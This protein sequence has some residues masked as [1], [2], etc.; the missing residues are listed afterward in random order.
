MLPLLM[1][2]HL[3]TPDSVCADLGAGNGLQ[4]LLLQ[5]LCPHRQTIQVELSGKMI[6]VGKLYQQALGLAPEKIAWQHGNI[7]D[8][9][10]SAM[11]LIYLYRPA[12]PLNEGNDLYRIIA[13]KLTARTRPVTII[14]LADCLTRFLPERFARVYKSEFINIFEG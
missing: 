9:D 7:V 3:I 1:A 14:S 10:L 4:G 12:R 13:D 11:D 8:A 5:Q 2:A 6:E